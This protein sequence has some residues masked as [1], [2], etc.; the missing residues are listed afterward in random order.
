MEEVANL[1]GRFS[2]VPPT[3]LTVGVANQTLCLAPFFSVLLHI[4]NLFLVQRQQ[5]LSLRQQNLESKDEGENHTW[6][7]IQNRKG[8]K[9]EL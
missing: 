5:G 7:K 6:C 9:R 3:L 1:G 8:L 4:H 2:S